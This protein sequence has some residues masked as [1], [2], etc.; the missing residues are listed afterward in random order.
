MVIRGNRAEPVPVVDRSS[1]YLTYQAKS[2]KFCSGVE[3]YSLRSPESSGILAQQTDTVVEVFTLFGESEPNTFTTLQFWHTE[4]Y[5][6][7]SYNH[8]KVF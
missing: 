1:S 6:L 8:M 4:W 3:H 7:K 2:A 5:L